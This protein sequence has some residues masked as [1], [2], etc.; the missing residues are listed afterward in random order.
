[1]SGELRFEKFRVWQVVV[2]ARA[3]ILA[4]PEST[5]PLYADNLSWPE[6]PIYIVE[7]MTS[8]GFTAVGECERGTSQAAVEATLRDLLGRD[9]RTLA[10]A[11]VWMAETAPHSVPQGYPLWSW[12][13]ATGRSY[14]L[15]ESLWLDA[16]GKA[17]GMP[18]CQLLGGAVRPAVAVDF[19]ANRPE[20]KTLAALIAEAH[21]R[22]L[23]GIKVKSDAG[24]DT[25]QSLMA[26]AADVPHNFRVTIDPMS[27]WRSLRDSV[28]LFEGLAKLA[29]TVQIEDPFPPQAM[30]DWRRA[31]YF[32]PLTIVCHPRREEVLRLAL[33]AEMADA[34]NL[35]CGSV[36]QFM[37]MVQVAEFYHK[38]CWQGSSLELGVLQHMRL[39]ASA[40][41][42][43]CVLA[44]DLQSEWVR[45]HTLVTP[46]M[47]YEDGAA[48][49][50]DTPGLGVVLDHDAVA[51][52]C[53]LS[54]EVT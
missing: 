42:R 24:G 4:A 46:R 39:H 54:F 37:H 21:G 28:R 25:A 15:L 12:Q 41:V 1:M 6:L 47:V 43:S 35:G 11:T 14:A 20:A 19:W 22:G 48:L 34:Y 10:P 17:A 3:D 33:A 5:K 16:I 29:C 49:V 23:R 8:E 7:G 45:E 50:P 40:C 32:S 44:S 51:R 27:A 18:A 26:I 53:R 31:R 52:Y 36:Y 38:D 2:P 30:E 9:L 13:L